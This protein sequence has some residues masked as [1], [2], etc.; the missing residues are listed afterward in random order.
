MSN[1]WIAG[2]SVFLVMSL[3]LGVSCCKAQIRKGIR[4]RTF[5]LEKVT[6]EYKDII[7][8]MQDAYYRTNIEGK[9][10]WVSLACE[11][12]T[13]YQREELIGMQLDDL[14]YEKGSG[15]GFLRA[16]ENSKGDLQHFEI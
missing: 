15:E 6:S 9:I 13:G 16:L 1:Y 11:R 3:I 8:Q 2:L 7:D 12:Q 14:Y 4:K 10:I 5:D